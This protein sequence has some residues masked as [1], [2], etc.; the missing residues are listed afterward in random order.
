MLDKQTMGLPNAGGDGSSYLWFLVHVKRDALPAWVLFM[1]AHETAW[2]HPAPQTRSMLVDMNRTGLLFLNVNHKPNGEMLSY[3]EDAME[4]AIHRPY[5]MRLRS[6]LLAL[7][8]PYGGSLHYPCCGQFWVH[9]SLIETRPVAYF[10]R[11]YRAVTEPS[12]PY[13]QLVLGHSPS[14]ANRTLL[15][16]GGPSLDSTYLNRTTYGNFFLENYWH[17]IFLHVEN[18]PFR[19]PVRNYSQL[20]LIVSTSSDGVGVGRRSGCAR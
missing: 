8:K 4:G 20:P 13:Y 1:H 14:V 6:E 7:R 12:D 10:E 15:G 11:L 19:L 9:R 17:T 16:L 3:N 18:Y 5:H 2:H